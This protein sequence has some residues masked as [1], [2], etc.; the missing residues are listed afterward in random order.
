M[1][2]L[3]IYC[4]LSL[5]CCFGVINAKLILRFHNHKFK[6]VQFTDLHWVESKE[7]QA[8]DDST[9]M[10]I[11]QIIKTEKP[12]LV[13]FTGDVVVSSGAAVAWKKVTQPM[14]DF[15]VPFVITFGNHDTE[16]DLSKQ[17][18]LQIIEQNPYNLTFNA[19][20]NIAGVGN[21]SLPVKSSVGQVDKWVLYFFDSHAYTKDTLYGYY[22]WIK[23]NQIQWYRQQSE[24]YTMEQDKPLPSLAFFHIPFPEYEIVRN[25]KN[26]LGSTYESVCSPTLNSGLFVSFVEMRD[27]LGV[28]VGHDHNN[29]FIGQLDG[30]WLA[31]GRK[32]GYNAAYK[33]VLERGAR[34]IVLY[35]NQRKFDTYIKTLNKT[36]F[37]KTCN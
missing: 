25:Q 35:E 4:I 6:I 21:C 15:K 14:I 19:D 24:H 16:T 18:M 36:S 27:V 37:Y 7:Y 3:K 28:F 13:V 5:L 26:T 32:T 12:D 23:F 33:E 9:L 31:Y 1:K 20:N 22:D 29:D 34:V 8:K 10:L 30:I 11:K 17:K 2:T